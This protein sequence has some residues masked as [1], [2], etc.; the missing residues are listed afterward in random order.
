MSYLRE[1]MQK[2]AEANPNR[3]IEG[4]RFRADDRE[5]LKLHVD[6]YQTQLE[7]CDLAMLQYEWAWWT[8]HI[9]ALELC[10]TQPEMR[11]QIGGSEQ[12]ERLLEESRECQNTL[13]D[14]MKKRMVHPSGHAHAIHPSEHA[15]QLSSETIKRDW[16]IS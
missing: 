4:G 12:T 3:P 5:L 8:E 7:S 16:G 6:A 15:W 11:E 13:I 10:L 2:L 14:E 1:I 9:E